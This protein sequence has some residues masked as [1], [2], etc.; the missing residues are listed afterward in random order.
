MTDADST[1][2][3]TAETKQTPITAKALALAML[4]A[5]PG[6]RFAIHK[7]SCVGVWTE[8]AG[9]FIG[10]FS[11]AISGEW[12][13]WRPHGL[14]LVNGKPAIPDGEW[15]EINTTGASVTDPPPTHI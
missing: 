4:E 15:V 1:D 12:V 10:I 9:R 7:N 8:A 5:N 2:A 11:T 3:M 6:M 13:D 14:S